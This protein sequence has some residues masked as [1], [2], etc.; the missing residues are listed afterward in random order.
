MMRKILL[1]KVTY[2]KFNSVK[3]DANCI[4]S[5]KKTEKSHALSISR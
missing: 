1:F 3:E 2:K 5:E 4:S